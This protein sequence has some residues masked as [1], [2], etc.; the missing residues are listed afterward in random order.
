MLHAVLPSRDWNLP[1]AH[2]LHSS[3]P[4]LAAT[5][6]GEQGVWAMEPVAHDEPAGHAVQ[7]E[8]ACKP[9]ELE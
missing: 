5:V 7:S 8:A 2:L 3:A 6:P 9:A 4:P 1:E